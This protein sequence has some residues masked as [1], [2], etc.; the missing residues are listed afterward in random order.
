[1]GRKPAA[2][3]VSQILTE[4]DAICAYPHKYQHIVLIGFSMGAVIARRLFLA[5]TDVH[6]TVPN[7]PELSNAGLR[8][9]TNK[10]ERIV[11]LGA[12][13][14]GW[15]VSGRLGWAY[16][17]VTNFIGIWGHLMPRG[18]K[19]TLFEARRGAPFIVQTRLQWLALRQSSDPAKPE[20]L[21]IQLLG[22]QDNLVAPDDTVDFAVDRD[23]KSPYFYFQLPHTRHDNAIEFTPRRFSDPDGKF[24]AARREQFVSVLTQDKDWLVKKQIPAENLSDTLPAE[25]DPDVEHVVFVVHGIRDDG[26][27]TRKIAQRIREAASPP[28]LENPPK[29]RCETSSYGYFA[30]LPFVLPWIRRQK[31]E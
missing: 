4:L 29:W 11:T 17:F 12:M 19:P 13:N 22:T 9:W 21:V 6:K 8:A 31:V 2:K 7:E 18:F 23:Q 27:W 15:L 14:R 1:M 28:G 24:G 5:A 25:P 10:V 30:M 16:S 3:I 20:P 26:Y